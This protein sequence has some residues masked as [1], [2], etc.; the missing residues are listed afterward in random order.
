MGIF[1]QKKVD[2]AENRQI[3]DFLGFFRKNRLVFPL[4]LCDLTNSYISRRFKGSSRR[5]KPLR[6]LR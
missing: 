4:P 2:L 6:G 3:W 5:L 1:G